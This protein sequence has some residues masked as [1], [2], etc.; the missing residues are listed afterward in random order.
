MGKM[1][2]EEDIKRIA[3]TEDPALLTLEERRMKQLIPTMAKKGQVLNPNGRPKGSIS[4]STK[5]R[6]LMEDEDFLK[7][8]L[9]GTPKQWE[10]IVEKTPGSI[11]AAGI[12]ANATQMIGESVKSGKPINKDLRDIIELLNK[13][14]YGEKVVHE[15]GES[16]FEKA[17]FEFNV[18][19]TPKLEDIAKE[20]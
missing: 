3:A 4:W 9:S 11:I 1:F 10:G 18:V 19:E 14:G 2:S 20:D 15:A 6:K 16:F 5:V 13:I 17:K 12:V 7:T 8:I